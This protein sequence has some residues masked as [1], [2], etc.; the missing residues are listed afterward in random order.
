MTEF[1][2]LI[3]IDPFSGLSETL[4]PIFPTT[5][6]M[7]TEEQIKSQYPPHAQPAG[8]KHGESIQSLMKNLNFFQLFAEDII[9]SKVVVSVSTA[10]VTSWK[11]IFLNSITSDS[12]NMRFNNASS[13][14][15]SSSTVNVRE[16]VAPN[17]IRG[18]FQLSFGGYVTA[19][20]PFDASSD[21]MKI[22]LM[23]LPSVHDTLLDL[24]NI[25]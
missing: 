11:I 25:G 4:G 5:V 14:I 15:V 21:A 20:L 3:V 9:V 22:A 23:A 16:L 6:A 24:G 19:I 18:D 7:T 2:N 17:R 8:T 12:F 10:T 1:I 13:S